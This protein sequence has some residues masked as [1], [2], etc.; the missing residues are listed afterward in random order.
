[1]ICGPGSF[2]DGDVHVPA[3][4]FPCV[5]KYNYVINGAQLFPSD[6]FTIHKDPFDRVIR[7]FDYKTSTVRPPGIFVN[8]NIQTKAK[9]VESVVL[10]LH[11]QSQTPQCPLSFKD[12]V[13]SA[14]VRFPPEVQNPI[15]YKYSIVSKKKKPILELG[16]PHVLWLNPLIDRLVICVVDTWADPIDG[17]PYICRPLTPACLPSSQPEFVVEYLPPEPQEAVFVSGPIPSLGGGDLAS[18]EA[19]LWDGAWIMRKSIRLEELPFAF[20]LHG[21]A[22]GRKKLQVVPGIKPTLAHSHDIPRSI[23]VRMITGCSLR[24]FAVYAPLVSLWT[25]ESPEVGDFQTL[26]AF[27]RWAKR[28]GIGQ[29]H[30][31]IETLEHHLIDPVHAAIAYEHPGYDLVQ[32]RDAKLAELSKLFDKRDKLDPA[33]ESFQNGTQWV[34]ESC[35]SPFMRWVQFFLFEQYRRAFQEIVELGVQLIT[36]F[37]LDLEPCYLALYPPLHTWSTLSHGIRLIGLE[38]WVGPPTIELVRLLFGAY[39]HTI[40]QQF[41]H[42]SDFAIEQV[43]RSPSSIEAGLNWVG[44]PSLKKSLLRKLVWFSSFDGK[45]SSEFFAD[46]GTAVAAALIADVGATRILGAKSIANDFHF[47]PSSSSPADRAMIIPGYLSP[48]LITAWPTG[49][50]HE[51]MHASLAEQVTSPALS[52]TVYLH[53]LGV[54]IGRGESNE[55]AP[56]PIQLIK[57][58]CRFQFPESIQDMESETERI[59]SIQEIP[60]FF[61]SFTN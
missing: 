23:S 38:H 29:I 6:L 48:E 47:I 32:V 46:C 59:A 4:R 11:G 35:D 58:H 30:V 1:M 41:F 45:K 36:D 33:F 49:E 52:V 14:E 5:F 60:L 12:E 13:W 43:M 53:D 37:V 40:I 2:W 61:F 57:D 39:S 16:R 26:V 20:K 56:L 21:T 34:V 50:T 27:A 9:K 28:C 19:L 15:C 10:V 3:I 44:S 18:A 54:M 7:F 55:V 51:T 42:V 22:L 25:E 17:I 8:F 31:H 24:G